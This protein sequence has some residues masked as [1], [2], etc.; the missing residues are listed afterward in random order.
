MTERR[1][2]R[3]AAGIPLLLLGV[4]AGACGSGKPVAVT[5]PEGDVPSAGQFPHAALTRLLEE[6]VTPEGLVDYAAVERQKDLLDGYLG[7][8]ARVSPIGQPHLFPTV[9]DQLAYWINAHNATALKGVL[10]L[11][12]PRDLSKVGSR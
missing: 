3:R 11:G 2:L 7:E 6:A 4:L 5:K 8:V 1:A 12:R 10:E 9:E